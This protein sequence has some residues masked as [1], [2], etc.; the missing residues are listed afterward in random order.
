MVG[1][2]DYMN[3]LGIALLAGLSII[4]YLAILPILLKKKDFTYAV[5]AIIE[6]VVLALAASGILKAGEH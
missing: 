4:C 2:G 3:L 5:I 1:K 6:V